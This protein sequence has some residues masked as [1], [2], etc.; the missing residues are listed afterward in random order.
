LSSLNDAVAGCAFNEINQA[1]ACRRNGEALMHTDSRLA[2][3]PVAY[4]KP[5]FSVTS[6]A[7]SPASSPSASGWVRQSSEAALPFNDFLSELRR[8]ERRAER[9]GRA[10]SLVMYRFGEDAQDQAE[11]GA[12]Q[13]A[14]QPAERL[15]KAIYSTKRETDI[16]GYAAGNVVALLCPD[17]D[18][19]GHQCVQRKIRLLTGPSP[20]VEA[21]A[22]YPDDL[23]QSLSAGASM[24][25]AFQPFPLGG[26]A[27]RRVTG[28]ALKRSLDLVLSSV[29]LLLL[30]LPM[31]GVAAAIRLTTPGAALFKQ[32]RLGRGGVPFT[33]YKF[34]SMVVDGDDRIHREFASQVIKGVVPPATSAASAARA[35]AGVGV[36]EGAVGQDGEAVLYKLKSDPR[37]TRLGKFIRQ[38][39]IDELPQLFNVLKGD[40]SLVGPRPPI[41]YESVHYQPW[42]LRRILSAKPGITGLWQVGGRSTVS[43][44][45]M[46]RMDLHYMNH[47]SLGLDLKILCKTVGVVLRCQGAV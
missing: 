45:E 12:S 36:G 30:A 1:L 47:C 44:S 13:W 22:T 29:A 9:S 37:V 35:E 34:R 46:V 15:I 20:C 6:P 41:P 27:A 8:E 5:R 31:L 18:A 2:S 21:A 42:H 43:F 26:S 4:L 10:L 33:F 17:T 28:Y 14:A 25:T 16:V 39:S 32:T 38:T 11:Q 40:M 7:G 3:N 24:P 23:F 19:A